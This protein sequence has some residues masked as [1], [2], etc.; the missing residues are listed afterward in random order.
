M[1]GKLGAS[2]R[3]QMLLGAGGLALLALCA[4]GIMVY[5]MVTT[6]A[7]LADA[8]AAERRVELFGAL[9][10]RVNDYAV[11]A[12]ELS[13]TDASIPAQRRERLG[14]RADIVETAFDS[15]EGSLAA[16]VGAAAGEIEANRRATRSLGLARMRAR[17]DQLHTNLIGPDNDG[18][19][20]RLRADLDTFAT[21]FSPLLDF[22]IGEERRTRRETLDSLETLRA[23]MVAAALAIGALA[24]LAFAAFQ[25]GVVR[26][27]VRRI[28]QTVEAARRI[29]AG[30][31]GTRLPPNRRDEFGLL[32]AHVNRM[33]SRLDRRAG[34]VARDRAQLS[35]II[36]ARTEDLR[37][38]NAAL[39][40]VDRDRRRF[41]SDVSHELRTPLTVILGEAEI[42]LRAG[43]LTPEETRE[44]LALIHARARRLG[45]RIDDL[46]R[47]ARSEGG[48]IELDQKPFDLNAAALQAAEDTAG[49]AKR[50]GITVETALAEEEMACLGDQDWIR[51]VVDGL[52]DNAIRHSPSGARLRLMTEGDAG[53]CRVHLID[54]GTGIATDEL[55]AVFERFRRGRRGGGAAGFGVGLA[56]AR[57]V[58][59]EHS[60]TIAIHSPPPAPLPAPRRG[61]GTQVTIGLPRL[62]EAGN[63]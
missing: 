13:S 11:I 41:F 61:P 29:G 59:E 17:F 9:S 30:Q 6:S 52:F 43:K 14:A 56:L 53:E 58:I 46:L 63:D 23:R 22:A 16:Y 10:A 7:R 20:D 40:E 25:L 54:E 26:P 51:Q 60:G 21:Q 34:R 12:I 55:E 38:A 28:R 3:V 19:G 49:L 47:I 50:R 45:R 57:W 35:E 18:S 62:F 1:S 37:E 24:L 4:C 5:G 44:S 31:F 15:V 8:A 48:R 2:L 32:F 42:G 27:L 39:E 36:E 33:A